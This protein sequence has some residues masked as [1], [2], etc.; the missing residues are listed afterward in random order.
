MPRPAPGLKRIVRT[1]E[2][3]FARNGYDG[4]S[5]AEV[6]RVAG[7]SKAAVFHHFPRKIDLYR[8]IFSSAAGDFRRRMA[9]TLDFGEG[10]REGV[11]RFLRAR[12][13]SHKER[14][15][16]VRLVMREM[17]E[18]SSRLRGALRQ[19]DVAASY[20]VVQNALE[21]AQRR[22]LIRP[23][24]DCRTAAHLLIMS[25]STLFGFSRRIGETHRADDETFAEG[26]TEMLTG[27]LAGDLSGAAEA[28]SG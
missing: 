1:A 19:A 24:I 12:A 18:G 11:R 5:V 20:R 13:R 6:A 14:G 26:M 21:D 28:S 22:G 4:V 25:S 16:A 9:P 27:G 23:Q 17:A 10:V 15:S 2:R 7:V 3:L 8:T